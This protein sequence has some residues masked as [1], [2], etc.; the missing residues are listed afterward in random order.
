[1][2]AGLRVGKLEIQR[3]PMAV[4]DQMKINSLGFELGAE[5]DAVRVLAPIGLEQL[6]TM[7]RFV[8]LSQELRQARPLVFMR[9]VAQGSRAMSSETNRRTSACLSSSVQSNQLV[10]LSWQ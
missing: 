5:R 3:R 8:G 1:M 10:S 6:D 7:P 2:T 4:Q 9:L